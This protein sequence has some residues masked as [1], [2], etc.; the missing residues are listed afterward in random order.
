MF[1][2]AT[3]FTHESAALELAAGIAA[4]NAGQ[5]AFTFGQTSQIDSSAVACMLAWKRH[6]QQKGVALEFKDLSVNLTHLIE[7]Y[8]VTEFL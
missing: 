5:V 3:A 4:I 7:L 6:A 2:P 8:G 1:T